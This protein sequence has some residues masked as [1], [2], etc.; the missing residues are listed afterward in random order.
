MTE[1]QERNGD[2]ARVNESLERKKALK[3]KAQE[4]R[5]VKKTVRDSLAEYAVWV[6][7][8]SVRHLL[9]GWQPSR[10][11]FRMNE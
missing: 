3:G 6:R 10:R 7:K 2:L 11:S 9:E 4:C 5:Q 8:P 1:V